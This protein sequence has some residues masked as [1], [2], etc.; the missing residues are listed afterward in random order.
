MLGQDSL[1]PVE[2]L[3]FT[4]VATSYSIALIAMT[5]SWTIMPSEITWTRFRSETGKSVQKNATD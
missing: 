3:M 1:A 5:E 2:A 4:A